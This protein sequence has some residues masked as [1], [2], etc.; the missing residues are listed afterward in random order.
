MSAMEFPAVKSMGEHPYALCNLMSADRLRSWGQQAHHW[1]AENSFAG[2]AIRELASTGI[3][4]ATFS[5]DDGGRG[6][7]LRQVLEATRLAS[8]HTGVLGRVIVDSNLGPTAMI[9]M[10]GNAAMR[11]EVLSAAHKGNKAAIA[12]TEAEAGSSASDLTTNVS[13]DATGTLSLCGKKKWITGAPESTHYVVFAR[14]EALSG[15]R[16]IG[17]VLARKGRQ[18]IGFEVP[19]RMMGMRGL[20]EGSISFDHYLLAE[21][22]III[23]PGAGFKNG[24]KIYNSQ[25]LGA[26]MVACSVAESALN[27]A[28]LY[29]RTRHQG[30]RPIGDYQGLRWILVDMAM[31]V[32]TSLTYLR[33]VADAADRSGNRFTPDP[34]KTAIAKI[35]CAEM[36]VRVT[37]AALQV[38]GA[39]GYDTKHSVERLCRDARMFTIAGGTTEIL[40]NLIGKAIV[41]GKPNHQRSLS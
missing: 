4:G 25:R 11:G 7:T 16:G 17:L 3:M 35:K 29:A 24:M 21:N 37:N 14:F 13:R 6:A 27:M 19:P 31:E 18:G 30:H 8:L 5:V 20:P 26:A 36:A 32:D 2:E 39:R 10:H 40:R 9:A 1:D 41:D 33:E 34:V 12:I 38:F 23:H 28:I 15:T 22:D